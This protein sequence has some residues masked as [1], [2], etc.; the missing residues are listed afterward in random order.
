[1]SFARCMREVGEMR[2]VVD[3]DQ[4]RFLRVCLAVVIATFI[5][6]KYDLTLARN[7]ELNNYLEGHCIYYVDQLQTH[8]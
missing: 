5:C 6:I 7:V 8:F 2:K 1:M 3:F 4:F